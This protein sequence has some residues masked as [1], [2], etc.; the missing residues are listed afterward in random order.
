MDQLQHRDTELR[1]RQFGSSVNVDLTYMSAEY[2]SVRPCKKAVSVSLRC[3]YVGRSWAIVIEM[4]IRTA[5]V[6]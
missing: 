3:P 6:G 4:S 2:T 5:R 1:R